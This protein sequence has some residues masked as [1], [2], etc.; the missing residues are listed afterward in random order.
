M[1]A[2][3]LVAQLRRHLGDRNYPAQ[4]LIYERWLKIDA[5]A[6][7]GEALPLVVG[8]DPDH[9]VELIGGPETIAAEEQLWRDFSA[10]MDCRENSELAVAAIVEWCRASG[11]EFPAAFARL[12]EFIQKTVL[13]QSAPAVTAANNTQDSDEAVIVLGAALSLLSK[14]PDRCRDANGFT[15]GTIITEL[16]LQTAARWFPD[17]GPRMSRLDIARL[18]DQW[19]E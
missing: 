16:M 9:W 6:A 10:A 17:S 4:D 5:W 19:L 8:A 18:I 14:M 7:R 15:D 1:S 12:Y 2:A 11:I 3:N 13:V